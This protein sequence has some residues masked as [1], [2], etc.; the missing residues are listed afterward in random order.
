MK[1]KIA[2]VGGLGNMGK[3]YC[4]ILKMHH[5]DH[6]VIDTS[7][8]GEIT[9]DTTGIIIAT[10]T[11]LHVKHLKYY[12]EYN[13]PILVEKPVTKNQAE[14]EEILALTV[15]IRMINQYEH[16]ILE[17]DPVKIVSTGKELRTT[18]YNYFKTGGDSLHWDVI[19]IIGLADD[20]RIRIGDD[21]PIWECWLNGDRLDIAKMDWAY[22]W[23]IKDWLKK[24]DDNKPYIKK[25]HERIFKI[26]GVIK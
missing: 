24:Y 21:S 22:V 23:N 14:L 1:H 9:D 15:P 12:A 5:I 4:A 17:R 10:P 8:P 16:Y 7:L 3:R 26:I 19:N 6:Y 25:A 20:G 18:Y 2:V 11:D 13:K